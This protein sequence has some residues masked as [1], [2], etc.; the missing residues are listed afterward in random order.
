MWAELNDGAKV[1]EVMSIKEINAIRARSK[2]KTSGPWFTDFAEMCRKTVVRRGTKYL[3]KSIEMRQAMELE[4]T[5]YND[6]P[7][8]VGTDVDEHMLADVQIE[9]GKTSGS[10]ALK[11]D[12]ALKRPAQK[13]QARIKF[14]DTLAGSVFSDE[15]FFSR[16]G[17]DATEITG[18]TLEQYQTATQMIIDWEA[19]RGIDAEAQETETQT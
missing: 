19:E 10:E 17:A 14:Q 11:R 2:S 7:K 12:L 18:W 16:I 6:Q 3:P 9:D 8:L 5:A 15:E 4:D 13:E 1:F